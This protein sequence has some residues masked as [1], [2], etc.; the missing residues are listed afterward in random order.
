MSLPKT[1]P[2]K[3]ADGKTIEIPSVGFGTWAAGKLRSGILET[4][5]Y[6]PAQVVEDG[7]KTLCSKL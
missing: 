6:I 1:F 7:A 2:L 3:A 4:E 5:A